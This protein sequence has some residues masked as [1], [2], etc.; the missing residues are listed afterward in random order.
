VLA[1][2]AVESFYVPLLAPL[3]RWPDSSLDISLFHLYGTPLTTGV[4]STG[5]WVML[6]VVL[7]GFGGAI[8]LVRVREVG[9]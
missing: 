8:A 2:V 5:L 3:F 1:I 6:A 9:R 7:G 4:Y